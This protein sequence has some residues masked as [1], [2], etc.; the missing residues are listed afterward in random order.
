MTYITINYYNCEESHNADSSEF[1]QCR[2]MWTD[3]E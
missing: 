3:E 1:L 2:K